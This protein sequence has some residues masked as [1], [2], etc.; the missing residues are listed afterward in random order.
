VPGGQVSFAVSPLLVD[1]GLREDRL[2]VVAVPNVWT[3]QDLLVVA[4][5]DPP[6]RTWRELVEAARQ[7]F[8]RLL[9][10]DS[11]HEHKMLAREPY[12]DVIGKQAL[13]LLGLYGGPGGG[14]C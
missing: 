10:P 1:H 5:N 4:A 13:T 6:I 3:V 8:P 14:W 12:S 9:I 2:G 11:V 7:R